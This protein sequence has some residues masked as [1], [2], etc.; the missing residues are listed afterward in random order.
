[1]RGWMGKK[2]REDWEGSSKSRL[3]REVSELNLRAALVL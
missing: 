3:P 1:M 2:E